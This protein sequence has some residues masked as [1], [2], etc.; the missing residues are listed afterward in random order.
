MVATIM[1]CFHSSSHSICMLSDRG[2]YHFLCD[3]TWSRVSSRIDL[4]A[5]LQEAVYLPP[6]CCVCTT[7]YP[8]PLG[9]ALAKSW[10]GSLVSI[11]DPI[12]CVTA[13][14]VQPQRIVCLEFSE[15]V[16]MVCCSLQMLKLLAS[17]EIG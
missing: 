3:G 12:Q 16:M 9:G 15:L 4:T 14:I 1:E 2:S 10:F 6:A 8:V 11:P 17:R 13:K 5:C 7:S